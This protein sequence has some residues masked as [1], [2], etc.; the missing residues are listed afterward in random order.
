MKMAEDE[1]RVHCGLCKVF[2][3]GDWREHEQSEQHQTKIKNL[4]GID[5]LIKRRIAV[6]SL[7]IS[8]PKLANMVEK[9]TQDV[10]TKMENI[11]TGKP[12]YNIYKPDDLEKK[13]GW[14]TPDGKWYSC[15]PVYHDAF[16][17]DFLE[18]FEEHLKDTDKKL[19]KAYHR[20]R[21]LYKTDKEYLQDHNGWFS[22][23]V[24]LTGVYMAASKEGITDE[25]KKTLKR[26]FQ[27]YKLPFHLNGQEV[28]DE[29]HDFFVS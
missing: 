8:N 2:V 20:H 16:A 5:A 18:W 23:T 29:F 24:G 12:G 17:S 11:L 25:Q 15:D 9:I 28:N 22:V 4:G 19:L 26:W 14:I 6:D 27:K 1:R 21:K 13:D 10:D 7:R 3:D